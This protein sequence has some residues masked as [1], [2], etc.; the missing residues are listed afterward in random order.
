MEGI[1]NVLSGKA[2][3]ALTRRRHGKLVEQMLTEKLKQI[4]RFLRKTIKSM[5]KIRGRVE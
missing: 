2:A 5:N 4:V 1:E 3:K